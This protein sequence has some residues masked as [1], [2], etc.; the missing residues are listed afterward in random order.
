MPSEGVVSN[1]ASYLDLVAEN[2]EGVLSAGVL[3]GGHGC[4]QAVR[5]ALVAG[6]VTVA[7][8]M[9]DDLTG[10]LDGH[11]HYQQ[12]VRNELDNVPELVA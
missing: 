2:Q 6:V 10:Y 5:A 8:G 12:E 3:H 11:G 9:W 1:C 7:Q 4:L